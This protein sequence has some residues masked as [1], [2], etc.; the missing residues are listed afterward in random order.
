MLDY[1]SI[2]VPFAIALLCSGLCSFI[3]VSRD[4]AGKGNVFVCVSLSVI[5]C[6][7][8]IFPSSYNYKAYLHIDDRKIS[9][10]FGFFKRVECEI[11]DVDFAVVEIDG[12]RLLLKDR[13]YYNPGSNKN[14]QTIKNYWDQLKNQNGG[15]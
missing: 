4:L 7:F 15:K 11:G 10:R 2:S 3:I 13:K 9:G 12:V 8:G 1:L 14:E 6:A 5:I